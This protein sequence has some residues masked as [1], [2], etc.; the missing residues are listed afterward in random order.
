MS[1]RSFRI[2]LAI[3]AGTLLAAILTA[4]WFVNRALAYADNRH[5]GSGANVEVEITSG[6]SFPT[7]ATTLADKNLIDKP[8]W[9]RLFAM[10]QGETTEVK[11]LGTYPAAGG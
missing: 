5:D 4:A 10:W 7:I 3:V 11:L 6:M 2:A 9:F 8:T 1:K